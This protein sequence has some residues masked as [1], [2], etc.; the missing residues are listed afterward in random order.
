MHKK[1]FGNWGEEQASL[2]LIEKGYRIAERNFALKMGEIDIIAWDRKKKDDFDTLCFIEVKTR[3]NFEGS[4]ERAVN[5]K[6]QKHMKRVAKQYC[7]QHGVDIDRVA[8][9]FE[10]VS[11]YTIGAE[12]K[13]FHYV[14]PVW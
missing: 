10:V 7:F 9:Q 4:A 5:K 2:F 12:L 13:F 6:K 3:A 11:V 14:L 8:I 1:N